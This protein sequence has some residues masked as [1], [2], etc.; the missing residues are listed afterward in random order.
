[1][2]DDILRQARRTNP[3]VEIQFSDDIFNE[4]LILLEDRCISINNKILCQLGLPAPTRDRNNVHDRD[5]VRERQYNSDELRHFVDAQKQLLTADQKIVL[6]KVMQHVANESGEIIFLDAPG[7]TGKTFLLNLILAE[8]QSKNDIALA[9]ALSGIASTLLD[10]GRTAHSA[11]KLP[12]NV[13]H[14]KTPTCNIGK[15]SGMAVVLKKSSLIVWDECTMAHKKSLEALDRTLKD[16]REKD[17]S[18]GGA[19]LLL[20]GDFRQTLPVIPRSTPANEL[21]ACLKASYLWRHVEKLTLSTNMRVHLLQDAAAQIFAKQLLDMGNGKLPIDP[22][23]REISFPPN[24]CQMQSS[25]QNVV[26]KVFP[27]I[28]KNFKNHDWLCERAILAPKNDDVNKINNQIQLKLSGKVVKYKSIDTVTDEA[29]AVNYPIEFLNSLE[30]SGMPPHIL[31]LK[32]GSPLMLIRNLDP[33]KL[34][35]GT[36]LAVKKLSPNLIEATIISGK[37]KGED[38]LIPRIPISSDYSFQCVWLLP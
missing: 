24:F 11:L 29:Q 14:T 27:D 5:L 18:M 19:L 16:F 2:S 4:A 12:L 21:N 33:P 37:C 32:V 35:N 9:V 34:C 3:N 23:T 15:N 7:D 30:P 38:V 28:T 17:R 20:A 1:M 31:T 26:H 13:N 8:I 22:T 10:G 6:E 36:R 25:I